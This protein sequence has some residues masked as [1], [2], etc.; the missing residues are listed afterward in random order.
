MWGSSLDERAPHGATFLF[1]VVVFK[2]WVAH[3]RLLQVRFMRTLR[4]PNIVLFLG[5][6][7]FSKHSA[8]GPGGVSFI[9]MEFMSRGTLSALL[10]N[11]EVH[12]DR[13]QALR[14][15]L[16]AAKGMRFLH[17]RT[18]PCIH[19]DLKSSNLLVSERWVVK[20]RGIICMPCNRK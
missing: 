9:V 10:R 2:D 20:V 12:I 8:I 16:D 13:C 11:G 6:G 1:T 17:G 15:A 7:R 3:F 4:H 19:R 14:F 5:G 18:P